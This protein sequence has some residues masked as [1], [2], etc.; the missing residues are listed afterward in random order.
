MKGR[1]RQSAAPAATVIY[2]KADILGQIFR[3]TPILDER[4]SVQHSERPLSEFE[5]C[6]TI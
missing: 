5:S 4:P 1:L 2:L 6:L 3:A